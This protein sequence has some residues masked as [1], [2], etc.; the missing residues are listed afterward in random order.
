MGAKRPLR[1]VYINIWNVYYT[2]IYIL[3]DAGNNVLA[4][5]NFSVFAAESKYI[6]FIIFCNTVFFL[7]N[8][9]NL[10]VF[11]PW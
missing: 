11:N 8:V 7:M 10:S 5:F 3:E 6:I 1:L 9:N 2:D 4:G